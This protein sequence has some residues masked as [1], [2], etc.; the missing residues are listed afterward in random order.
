MIPTYN[1]KN[2]CNVAISLVGFLIARKGA[3]AVLPYDIVEIGNSLIFG[4]R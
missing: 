3:K 2:T 1:N 4:T